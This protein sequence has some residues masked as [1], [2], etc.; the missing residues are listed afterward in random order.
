MRYSYIT[1]L[2]SNTYIHTYI[3]NVGTFQALTQHLP[4]LAE[5]RGDHFAKFISGHAVQVAVRLREV[6]RHKGRVD[7]TQHHH[8]LI[9]SY[10]YIVRI[11]GKHVFQRW[12]A[13]M[14]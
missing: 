12:V 8:N 10:L 2:R 3:H 13:S 4:S 1:I 5:G 6:H 11:I 14:H 7:L 9:H